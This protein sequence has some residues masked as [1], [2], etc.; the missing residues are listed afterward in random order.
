[1]H[2]NEL[3]DALKTCVE[4]QS[5]QF[6]LPVNYESQENRPPIVYTFFT[7]PKRQNDDA[8]HPFIV[9][10]P[11]GSIIAERDTRNVTI[12]MLIETFDLS[13]NHQGARDAI[14]IA[15]RLQ[16]YFLENPILNKR[17][18][19]DNGISINFDPEQQAPPYW[20]VELV[21]TWKIA[22]AQNIQVQEYI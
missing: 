4:N 21:S 10:Q 22:A 11:S 3:L 17:F 6:Y 12:N 18:S 2:I 5:S 13:E 16:T 7:P 9:I 20:S 14:N 19:C 15:E 1:M 8:D